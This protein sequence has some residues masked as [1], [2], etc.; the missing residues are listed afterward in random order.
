MRANP[1]SS[2]TAAKPTIVALTGFMAAGKSTVARALGASL[3]WNCFDL[4]L[5][6]ERREKAAVREIFERRGE[7][8]F[9]QVETEV[10][11]T[12][13]SQA[14]GPTVIALGGGTFVQPESVQLLRRHKAL[15]VF[16]E[17]DV[18]LLLE[19]C[20]NAASRYPENP[21]PLAGDPVAFRALYTQRLPLYRQ[22]HITVTT[23]GSNIEKT[24]RA[25]VAAL[26]L[27]AATR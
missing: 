2:P 23:E 6:I 16:L 14:A 4:D 10:L 22:A 21:R 1:N 26:H 17:V 8:H 13:L 7:A 20:H 11:E 9:R 27:T 15:V 24:A 19:R 25:I 5:E 18:E 12:I 3:R